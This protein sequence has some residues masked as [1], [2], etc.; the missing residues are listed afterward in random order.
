MDKL[1]SVVIP[2]YNVENYLEK[3]LNSVK[4]QTYKNLEI[5]LVNDGSTDKS[6]KI[7]EKFAN[8]DKRFKLINKQ[9]E[10]V[11]VARNT[12]LEKANGE[13]VVFIDADDW[14]ETTMF[15]ELIVKQK[16]DDFDLVFCRFNKVYDDDKISINELGLEQFVKTGKVSC[17]FCHSDE[18]KKGNTVYLQENVMGSL[19]RILFKKS[20][21]RD[22]LFNKNV[23]FMEDVLFITK[24]L[25]KPLKLALVEKYLYNYYMR[26]TSATHSKNFDIVQNCISFINDIKSVVS[27]EIL[28]AI[29]FFCYSEC[30]M[31]KVS[32][33]N[34]DLNLIKNWN[35]KNNYKANKKMTKGFKVN[36]KFFCVRH[37]MFWLLKILKK[38]K[39]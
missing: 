14:L 33:N 21:L 2:V 13:F 35:N 7:C 38:I 8:E 6:L 36:L 15:E 18:R 16:E 24:V 4:N 22:V 37:N 12:G 30:V 34:V 32:G 1:I 39:G 27:A 10:G 20:V 5:I 17:F 23:K 3:C 26:E 9:N 28:S 31:S 29:K 11:S 19:C 25:S